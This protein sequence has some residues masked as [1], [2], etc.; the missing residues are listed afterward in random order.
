MVGCGRARSPGCAQARLRRRVRARTG[1][2]GMVCAAWTPP[3]AGKPSVT[4]WWSPMHT[5][6]VYWARYCDSSYH[7]DQPLMPRPTIPARRGVRRC[8]GARGA[9]LHVEPS[10]P[11][12]AGLVAAVNGPDKPAPNWCR[13]IFMTGCQAA[14]GLHDGHRARHHIGA[15][16]RADANGAPR[17]EAQLFV[18]DDPWPPAALA[19]RTGQPTHNHYVGARS[20]NTLVQIYAGI[21]VRPNTAAVRVRGAPSWLPGAGHRPSVAARTAGL[22]QEWCGLP[23][24]PPI[25]TPAL[26]LYRSVGFQSSGSACASDITGSA[27]PTRTMRR[28]SGDPS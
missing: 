1:H 21:A 5:M 27:A 24:G 6:K 18:G 3:S 4:R 9:V 13:C 8:A 14:G 26:A 10:R 15:L 12:P 19:P 2:P 25:M 28:D 7:S 20:S 17:L 22:C 11:S 23:G 16:T